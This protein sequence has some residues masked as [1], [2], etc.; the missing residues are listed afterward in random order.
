MNAVDTNVLIYAHDPREPS[1]QAT[2]LELLASLDDGA[3]LWQVACEF[4]NASRK[5]EPLGY[6]RDHAW[7]EVAHLRAIWSTIYPGPET[8]ETARRI[9]DRY[10][11]SFWDAMILAACVTAGVKRLY[12][13]DFGGYAEVE[14]VEIVDPFRAG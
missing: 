7:R 1:K 10:S 5:L 4:L 14:G 11:L 12:T 6:R 9:L 2:A 3:L 8:L 13:E